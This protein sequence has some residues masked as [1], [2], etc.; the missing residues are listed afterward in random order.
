M[1]IIIPRVRGEG[2]GA[3]VSAKPCIQSID[4]NRKALKLASDCKI[5]FR[6]S[7]SDPTPETKFYRFWKKRLDKVESNVGPNL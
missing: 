1:E 7:K 5:T 2:M 6:F 3:S 4:N